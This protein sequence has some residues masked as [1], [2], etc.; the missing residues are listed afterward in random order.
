MY[1]YHNLGNEWATVEK[2]SRDR[3]I[4]DGLSMCTIYIYIYIYIYTAH[5]MTDWLS[6]GKNVGER[7]RVCG[8]LTIQSCLPS[9]VHTM[10]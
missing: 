6:Q 1:P 2:A 4:F 8:A 7:C 3:G 9:V 10:M 5:K